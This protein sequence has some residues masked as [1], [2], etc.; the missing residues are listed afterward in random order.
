MLAGHDDYAELV[1]EVRLIRA[2]RHYDLAQLAHLLD[3]WL[4]QADETNGGKFVGLCLD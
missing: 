3:H 4:R 1:L 2:V